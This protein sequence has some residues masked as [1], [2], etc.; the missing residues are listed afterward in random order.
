MIPKKSNKNVYGDDAEKFFT[1]YTTVSS[2]GP[3]DNNS[4][5]GDQVE[6]RDYVMYGDTQGLGKE[7][8]QLT[9]W[10]SNLLEAY[11]DES[12]TFI[13]RMV[14][15]EATVVGLD[16][17]IGALVNKLKETDPFGP[18]SFCVKPYTNIRPVRT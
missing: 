7:N 8:R 10:Y 17:A 9:N 18:A 6:Y 12:D 13:N 11:G 14:N 15:Y 3:Y 5:C 2:H 4:K 16:R 1:F